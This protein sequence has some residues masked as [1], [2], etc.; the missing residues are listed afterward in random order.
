MINLES[1]FWRVRGRRIGFLGLISLATLCL[2]TT[3]QTNHWINAQF[4]RDDI[5]IAAANSPA[6]L[7]VASYEGLPIVLTIPMA[8]TRAQ[9][10]AVAR[11]KH[12]KDSHALGRVPGL[13]GAG[14][15]IAG[16]ALLQA[17]HSQ[18]GH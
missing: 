13:K 7:A 15:L 9:H 11:A 4:Q 10:M 2:A 17:M 12:P 18:G 16:L 8:V 1:P 3:Y 6:K 5:P 14:G